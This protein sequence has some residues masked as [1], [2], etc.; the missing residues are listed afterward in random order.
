MY[1][2]VFKTI[3]E[4]DNEFVM[5]GKRHNF[6]KRFEMVC[7]T[8]AMKEKESGFLAIFYDDELKNAF[9]T[10]RMFLKEFI[11]QFK[12]SLSNLY[13]LSITNFYLRYMYFSALT[14]L[15]DLLDMYS[16]YLLFNRCAITIQKTWLDHYY[17]PEHQVCTRRLIREH[18]S[19][20]NELFRKSKSLKDL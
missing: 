10:R 11:E 5:L 13:T 18:Q 17:N 14:C 15:E 12:S 19:F 1:L 2:N 3:N 4:Q 6:G 9:V 16:T 20:V 8:K 7:W